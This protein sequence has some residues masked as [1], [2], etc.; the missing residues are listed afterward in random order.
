MDILDQDYYSMPSE[1]YLQRNP[2]PS[3]LACSSKDFTNAPSPQS[4]MIFE[5]A[6][7]AKKLAIAS[8]MTS[9]QQWSAHLLRTGIF[10]C[11][12]KSS[13]ILNF[14]IL[15]LMAS[16]LVYLCSSRSFSVRGTTLQPI[17]W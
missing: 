5:T 14:A 10:L 17:S 8:F 9:L 15:W 6:H 16:A 4:L 12:G 2:S 7:V 11:L 1:H 3:E 13:G